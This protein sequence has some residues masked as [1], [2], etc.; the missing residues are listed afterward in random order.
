LGD[1]SLGIS[2]GPFYFAF[3]ETVG[4]NLFSFGKWRR[5]TVDIKVAGGAQTKFKIVPVLHKP[6]DAHLFAGWG[7]K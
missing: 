3:F 1:S 5:E 2:L 7:C 4:R 6:C